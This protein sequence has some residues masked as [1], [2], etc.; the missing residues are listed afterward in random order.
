MMNG[1]YL[2]DG[3]AVGVFGMALSAA[4]CDILWTR[5]KRIL[6]AVSMAVILLFQGAI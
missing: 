2:A 6:M 3:I 5:R 1:L 4:F